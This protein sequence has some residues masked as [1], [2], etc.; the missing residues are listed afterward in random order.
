MNLSLCLIASCF[1]DED[2]KWVLSNKL[3]D[4]KETLQRMYSPSNIFY[5]SFIYL[6]TVFFKQK[7][8]FL[9]NY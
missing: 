4:F 7:M 8:C 3:K 2:Y 1:G 5:Y 9:V 6:I